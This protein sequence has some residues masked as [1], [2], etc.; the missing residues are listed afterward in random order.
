MKN[1][2]DPTF[3]PT[4][5]VSSNPNTHPNIPL[6][7][8]MRQDLVNAINNKLN[9]LEQN[10]TFNTINPSSLGIVNQI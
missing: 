9:H 3:I 1:N 7:V 2:I 5:Y 10:L 6:F 4:G 8:N